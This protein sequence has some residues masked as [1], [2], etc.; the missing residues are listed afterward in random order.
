MTTIQY[1]WPE[2]VGGETASVP[3]MD[4]TMGSGSGIVVAMATRF[5]AIGGVFEATNSTACGIDCGTLSPPV[6][7]SIIISDTSLGA[8]A[9]Y[10][11]QNGF[12]LVGNSNRTCLVNSTW[13]GVDPICQSKLYYMWL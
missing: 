2:T 13:S 6:N 8:M 10:S 12:S 3:C 9:V 5:C 11:C 1:Y 4:N 7:G